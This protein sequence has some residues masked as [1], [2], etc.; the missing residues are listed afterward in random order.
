V[1]S[2]AKLNHWKQ[3]FNLRI[4]YPNKEIYPWD[5]D[6]TAAFR[7]P[8]FNPE[9]VCAKASVIAAFLVFWI[10]L[11]FGDTTSPPNFEPL[12]RG[13]MALAEDLSATNEPVPEYAEYMDKVVFCPEPDESVV[14]VRA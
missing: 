6:V 11:T 10:G 4:S 8:K 9:V 7:I 1:F 13:R 5:D 2:T 14:F 3:I 12:A